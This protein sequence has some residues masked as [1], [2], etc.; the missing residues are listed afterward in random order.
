MTAPSGRRGRT[1]HRGGDHGLP[2]RRRGARHEG[3]GGHLA[4]A[5]WAADVAPSCRRPRPESAEYSTAEVARSEEHTSELQSRPHVVCRL[6][7][8]KKKKSVVSSTA[9]NDQ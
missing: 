5:Q 7:L 6:L 3:P 1:G 4:S 8:E 9:S 2:R